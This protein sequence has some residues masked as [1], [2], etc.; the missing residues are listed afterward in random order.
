M[1]VHASTK[2]SAGIIAITYS[3]PTPT[4]V[5]HV[6]GHT[7]VHLFI[8]TAH[9]WLGWFVAKSA[10]RS[11]VACSVR[12]QLCNMYTVE[13]PNRGHF[14]IVDRGFCP[15]FGGCP[16]VGGSILFVIYSRKRH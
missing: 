4:I 5:L 2:I 10:T 13:P 11:G 15:L 3:Q 8:H 16:L 9:E 6:C 14:R 7:R 1:C 12:L